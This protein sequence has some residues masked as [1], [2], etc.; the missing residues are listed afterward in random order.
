IVH[1]PKERRMPSLFARVMF[2]VSLIPDLVMGNHE[3]VCY[4][5]DGRHFYCRRFV[6]QKDRNAATRASNSLRGGRG[7][8]HHSGHH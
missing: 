4:F 1:R 6:S 3:K 7:G 8:S 2:K 5:V